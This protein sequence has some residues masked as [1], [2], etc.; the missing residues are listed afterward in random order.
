MSG[1]EEG[2]GMRVRFMEGFGVGGVS[3]LKMCYGGINKVVSGFVV[4]MVFC[5]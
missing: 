2:K 4:V 1:G 3:V 5:K